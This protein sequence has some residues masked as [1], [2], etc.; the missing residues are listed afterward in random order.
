MISHPLF[1]FFSIFALTIL[2]NVLK[3]NKE[4]EK[5]YLD[6]VSPIGGGQF[7]QGHSL[8]IQKKFHFTSLMKKMLHLETPRV[9]KSLLWRLW[10]MECLHS[11]SRLLTINLRCM[12]RMASWHI[13]HSFLLAQL[14]LFCLQC[15][16]TMRFALWQI[17]IIIKDLFQYEL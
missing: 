11:L 16:V 17:H 10:L 1:F 8:M 12:M 15:Q 13:Q 9:L 3:R 6:N 5:V 2:Y 14:R 7:L 4:N